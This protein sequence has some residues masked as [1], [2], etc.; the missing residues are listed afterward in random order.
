VL[1][2]ALANDEDEIRSRLSDD[3]WTRSGLLRIKQIVPWAL[4][5]GAL[6]PF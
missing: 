4:R 2:I 5:L 3:C 6:G 1:L